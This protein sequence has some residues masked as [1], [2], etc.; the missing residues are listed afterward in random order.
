MIRATPDIAIDDADVT[1]AFIRSSGP[2]G[3]NVNKVATGVQLR[4]DVAASGAL[5]DPVKRRLVRLAGRRM[6]DAGVLIITAT[7]HRT[8][9]ANRR[10]AVDRLVRLIR[11]AAVRPAPRVATAPTRASRQRRLDAKKRRAADKQLRRPP[12][13]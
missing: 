5:P 4:F 9:K 7:R 13:P 1:F 8:Q 6:T 10:D 2:G 12:E 3:Q 11:R